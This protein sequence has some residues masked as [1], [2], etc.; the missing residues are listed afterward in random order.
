MPTEIERKYLVI[1]NHWKRDATQSIS[2][3][4]GYFC[5]N[6]T[7]SIR[8]RVT[9][10]QAW[11]NFKSINIGIQRSEYEYEIPVADAWEMIES[12]CQ[13]PI[14]E[15]TRYLVPNNG[16]TWEIDVFEGKNSG[17]IIAE[18][19]LASKDQA[20][21]LPDW[22]GKEVT[23]QERYYNPWLCMHPYQQWT[24]SAQSTE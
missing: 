4:Q 14:I 10:K 24:Q 21:S 22:V 2:I 19:E 16:H 3:Q 7:V 9:D 20:F 23:D 1:N 13:K 17:L 15:K 12:L 6:D 5:H 8:V 18:L 11:L